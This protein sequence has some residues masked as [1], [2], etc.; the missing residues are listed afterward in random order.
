[1]TTKIRKQI[2][3]EPN[4]EALLKG[5][6]EETGVPEAEIIRR[7]IDQHTYLLHLL[8]RD[9]TAW[10]EERAFINQLIQQGS[11]PGRR[12]WQREELYER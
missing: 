3:I 4:Q 8:L 12:V 6:V 5:L 10:N 11:I 9:L 7:A 2:Y 1:M